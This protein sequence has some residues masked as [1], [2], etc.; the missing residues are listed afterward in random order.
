M[1]Q[2]Y[3]DDMP[4]ELISRSSTIMTSSQ[5]FGTFDVNFKSVASGLL[6]TNPAGACSFGITLDVLPFSSVV[7]SYDVVFTTQSDSPRFFLATNIFSS[8]PTD[9]SAIGIS[10]Y[11]I[12]LPFEAS[13]ISGGKNCFRL[14]GKVV[15]PYIER[16]NSF[17]YQLVWIGTRDNGSS[18]LAFSGFISAHVD[19]IQSWNPR[20]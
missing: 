19:A 7:V 11:S 14:K 17:P 10:P 16:P 9:G 8:I 3:I 6:P 15:V 2:N 20:K 1:F 18:P 12:P 4:I 5:V 13:S